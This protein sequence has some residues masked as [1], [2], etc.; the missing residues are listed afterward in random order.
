M[1]DGRLVG[2]HRFRISNTENVPDFLQLGHLTP[3]TA[4]KL[5][6]T[7]VFHLLHR[8][9]SEWESNA[10]EGLTSADQSVPDVVHIFRKG[11]GEDI[12][13]PECGSAQ[14]FHAGGQLNRAGQ[15]RVLK[16][17][18]INL[19]QRDGEIDAIEQDA[20]PKGLWA[21]VFQPCGQGHLTERETAQKSL[22]FYAGDPL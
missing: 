11:K 6:L 9:A 4:P 18:F 8:P 10:G 21:K 16:G 2:V 7:Q 19:D 3:N 5:A 12:R 15:A 14:A 1:V 22:I 20:V 17:P 13:G